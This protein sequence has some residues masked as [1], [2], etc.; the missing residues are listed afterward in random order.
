M[1]WHT[2]QKHTKILIHMWIQAMKMK[3]TYMFSHFTMKFDKDDR[4]KMQEKNAPSLL[5]GAE[6]E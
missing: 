2:E 5:Q 3:M 4:N 1:W 6:T